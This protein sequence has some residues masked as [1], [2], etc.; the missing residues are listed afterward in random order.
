MKDVP[1]VISE[2]GLIMTKDKKTAPPAREHRRHRITTIASK[3]S[4]AM[5]IQ[6]IKQSELTISEREVL[7]RDPAH[8]SHNGTRQAKPKG[9]KS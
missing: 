4:I 8:R 2:W 9:G 1:S 5:T 6:E 7:E 3:G